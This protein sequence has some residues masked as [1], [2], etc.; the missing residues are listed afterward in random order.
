MGLNKIDKKL[1][2]LRE[3]SKEIS[4]MIINLRSNKCLTISKKIYD[5]EIESSKVVEEIKIMETQRKL[6]KRNKV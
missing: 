2:D 3:R 5:L 1:Y 6:I 4:I